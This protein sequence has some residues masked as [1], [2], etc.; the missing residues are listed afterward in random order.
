MKMEVV[1]IMK[2]KKKIATGSSGCLG[3]S[4]I[5]NNESLKGVQVLYLKH[6]I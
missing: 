1:V 4:I 2:K 5:T 3:I 6:C